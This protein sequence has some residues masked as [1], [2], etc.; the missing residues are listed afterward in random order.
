VLGERGEAA[1]ASTA[2][3]APSRGPFRGASLQGLADRFSATSP[4]AAGRLP[5]GSRYLVLSL[6]FRGIGILAILGG[7]ILFFLVL[8]A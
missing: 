2:R 3:R 4:V 8:L 7:L 6:V 5:G 1:T